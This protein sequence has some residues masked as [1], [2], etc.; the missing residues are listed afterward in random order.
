M[1]QDN[2][3]VCFASRTLN[4]HETR[5]STIEKELLAI[6]WATKYF[7]P[8][9]YGKQFTIR[10]D[11]R[12]LVWLNSLKEPNAKLQRWKIKLG[13][14]N[15]DIE[16]VKGKDN[17]VA[18]GLSRMEAYYN[19][20]VETSTDNN[21]DIDNLDAQSLVA[22]IHSANED[23]SEHIPIVCT[24]VNIYKTQI[25]LN[26]TNGISNHKIYNEF[27]KRRIV[28][29]LKEFR[30]DLIIDVLKKFIPPKGI[31]GIFSNHDHLF[32]KFQDVYIR[33]FGKN[34]LLKMIKCSKFLG[35]LADEEK[36]ATVIIQTHKL[37]NHR[38]INETYAEIKDVYYAPRLKD[39]IQ[40]FINNCEVCNKAKYERQPYKI[41]LQKTE[42][43]HKP[44][45][46]IHIDIWYAN[47][48]LCMSQ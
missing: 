29:E 13:E 5:Y 27:G 38:G 19:E 47:L 8:Y 31:V 14:Y 43:P 23:S 20:N 16:Y 18:D 1:S 7:R 6:V 11:H 21:V 10:T 39:K 32:A 34:K 46:I 26:T 9:L 37:L 40:K 2:H 3:P 45:Q 33:Y 28:L 30:E 42:T 17:Q 41:P 35:D 25:I 48:I 22:T 44:N 24:P 36:L 4:E 15:F 12:P